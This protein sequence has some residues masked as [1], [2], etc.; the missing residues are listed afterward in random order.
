VLAYVNAVIDGRTAAGRWI[1]AAAQRFTRDLERSDLVMS[2]PDV[3]RVAEHFRSLNLVGEDSG[4]P[5]ELHPWQ[6]FV[7][8]NI[9]GW[10]LPDGP[11][12]L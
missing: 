2:W 3:E 8:A 10:R 12:G 4:K 11:E 1:Y 6:L 7:L 5:F 9:V